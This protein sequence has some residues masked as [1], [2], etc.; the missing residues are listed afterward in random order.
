MRSVGSAMVS[1]NLT[2]IATSKAAVHLRPGRPAPALWCLQPV[3]HGRGFES[4]GLIPTF[5]RGSAIKWRNRGPAFPLGRNR[6]IKKGGSRN[7]T[8]PAGSV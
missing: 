2:E 3:G 8:F 1:R 7:L 6:E 4:S 5:F